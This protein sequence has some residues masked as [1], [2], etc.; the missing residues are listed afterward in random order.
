[1]SSMSVIVRGATTGGNSLQGIAHARRA[2]YN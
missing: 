1:M 2:R